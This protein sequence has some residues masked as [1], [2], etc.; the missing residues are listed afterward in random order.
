MAVAVSIQL[1]RGLYSSQ[2]VT[3]DYLWTMLYLIKE[4]FSLSLRYFAN[5]TKDLLLT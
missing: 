1:E 3:A 4:V 5:S 2:E